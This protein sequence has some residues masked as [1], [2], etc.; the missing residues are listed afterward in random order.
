RTAQV[1]IDVTQSAGETFRLRPGMFAV[2][3]I[4]ASSPDRA[5]PGAVLAIPEE[6]V[7]SVEGGTAVFVPVAGE[8][9]TYAKRPVTVG[10][11]VGGFVPVLSGL[12]ENE[13]YVAAGSF[14]LKADLGKSAAKHE[15]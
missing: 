5:S 9:N 7:Q 11:A 1:R 15:H 2:A 8:A 13:A 4:A 12:G 10:A 6:A 3:E 14:I